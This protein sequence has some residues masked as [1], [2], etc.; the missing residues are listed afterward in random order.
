[1][2]ANWN[3]LESPP[4]LDTLFQLAADELR[5]AEFVKMYEKPSTKLQVAKCDRQW[6]KFNEACHQ[7]SRETEEDFR[8]RIFDHLNKRP[9]SS[10]KVP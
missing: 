9:L 6:K 1:M 2:R 10:K 5:L 7:M 3:D 4:S 8:E